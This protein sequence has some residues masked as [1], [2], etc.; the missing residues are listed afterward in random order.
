MMKKVAT[1]L[2]VPL[3]V[4]LVVALALAGSVATA[5]P[6]S[7]LVVRWWGQACFELR[8]PGGLVVMTDPFATSIG[9]AFPKSVRPDV[10]T[11]SHEH[12]DHSNDKDVAGS[13][14]VIR[15]L[16]SA[17]MKTHDWTKVDETIQGVRIRALPTY[18][19]MKKGAE[20]GKNAVFVFEEASS[21]A[22]VVHMGDLGHLLSNE[23]F[24]ELK[25]VTLGLIPVGGHF[26]I[27]AAYAQ[28]VAT[29]LNPTHAVIPMHYKTAALG[30]GIPLAPVDDFL[31][32]EKNPCGFQVKT[33]DGNE[34]VLDLAT[35]PANPDIVVLG[36]EP[37]K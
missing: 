31:T 28:S 22:R 37:K 19:D 15:G 32:W 29:G 17:D 12:G 5:Q 7:K 30:K 13:P 4:V 1:A 24:K 27:D 10:V 20:R 23:Q 25:G 14:K 6:E 33:V 11:I 35:K 2:A 8:F 9:Y 36:W 3:A 34:L 21:G 16:T 18:H 26:T